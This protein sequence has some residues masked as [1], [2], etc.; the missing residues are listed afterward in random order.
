[1]FGLVLVL[2][3]VLGEFC[4]LCARW[5]CCIVGFGMGWCLC[6]DYLVCVGCL[7]CCFVVVVDGLVA[8]GVGCFACGV[9]ICNGFGL[10]VFERFGFDFAGLICVLRFGGFGFVWFIGCWFWLGVSCV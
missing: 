3:I 6:F 2:V 1:M 8:V 7:C 4:D 9:Y 5:V 10:F